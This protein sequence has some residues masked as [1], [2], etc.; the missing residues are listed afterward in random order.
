MIRNIGFQSSYQLAITLFLVYKGVDA[1]GLD[2]EYL[3]RHDKWAYGKDED[4]EADYL[5][6]FVFNTFVFCQVGW[7][8]AASGGCALRMYEALCGSPSSR[9]VAFRCSTSSTRDPSR[10]V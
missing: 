5:G 6:T 3:I 7:N 4:P 10:T 2:R 8:T 1:F 9:R